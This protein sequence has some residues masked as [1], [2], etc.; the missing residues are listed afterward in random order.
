MEP[1]RF[2]PGPGL[3]LKDG[4][5]IPILIGWPQ[6]EFDEII[7]LGLELPRP[8]RIR[9]LVD[10]GSALTIVNP[11]LVQT[12]RLQ[13]TGE[14]KINAAGNSGTYPEFAASISFP[15]TSLSDISIVRIVACPL[16]SGVMSCLIGRDI[17]R[18]WQLTY[19]GRLGTFTIQELT[20]A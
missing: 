15:E 5:I 20:S 16:V 12:F 11:A 18:N 17:L 9:A 13:Q 14:A 1:H 7:A 10:T 4:P 6:S 19:N 3:L 2:G 8:K